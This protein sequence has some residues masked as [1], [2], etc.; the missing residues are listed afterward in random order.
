MLNYARLRNFRLNFG[1]VC[2]RQMAGVIR[3]HAQ[4]K[5][6][7]KLLGQTSLPLSCAYAL[8]SE[9]RSGCHRCTKLGLVHRHIGDRR[10]EF[11]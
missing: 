10:P 5:G 9:H 1:E 4:I 7:V 3:A 6:T 2:L 8:L 11:A